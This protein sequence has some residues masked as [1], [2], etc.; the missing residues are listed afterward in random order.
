MNGAAALAFWATYPTS[1]HLKG[2]TIDELADFLYRKSNH[3]LGRE[4][5]RKKAQH[6]LESCHFSFP[7]TLAFMS[8]QLVDLTQVITHRFPLTD[9][10]KAFEL[11]KKTSD[12][13]KILLIPWLVM[14]IRPI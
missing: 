11:G 10:L 3:R 8:R 13:A 9:V 6:I 5:S 2:V 12:S 1:S 7:K 14:L 4:A